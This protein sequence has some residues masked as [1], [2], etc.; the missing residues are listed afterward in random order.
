MT[1]PR[2][3]PVGAV[4][5]FTR[6]MLGLLE[7]RKPDYLFCAFDLPGPTFRD[8]LFDQYKAQ[9]D[10]NA[11]GPAAADRLDSPRARSDGDSGARLR[12]ASRP[13]TF[14]PR[15]RGWSMS[16]AANAF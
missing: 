2:G 10:R 7:Q 1:G 5:G 13:T 9:A 6:D 8:E 3:E 11:A 14:W 16:A 4:L 15:S 12:P